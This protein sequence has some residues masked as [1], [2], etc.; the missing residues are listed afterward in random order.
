MKKLRKIFRSPVTTIVM[1]IIAAGL[2]VTG[3]IGSARAALG[4]FS[5]DY[6]AEI[7]T[8]NIGIQIVENGNGLETGAALMGAIPAEDFHVASPYKEELAVRNSG[9]IEEY[10]RVVIYRYWADAQGNK[11]TT[12][13]PGL[14]GLNFLE[15]T[16]WIMDPDSDSTTDERVILYYSEPVAAGSTTGL[17]ADKLTLSESINDTVTYVYD[18]ENRTVTVV[19]PY[20]GYSFCIEMQADGVQTHNAAAAIL[21]AWG[22]EVSMS[23]RTITGVK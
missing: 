12:M 9:S 22:R 15:D 2:L 11:V 4:V 7:Q 18:E 1:F 10:V 5:E 16:G 3:G 21:S 6:V 8:R 19:Y 14:I 23:G 17:I 13:D 20:H